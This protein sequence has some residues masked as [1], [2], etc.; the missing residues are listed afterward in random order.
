M[1]V[2]IIAG[3]PTP[4]EEEAVRIAFAQLAAEDKASAANSRSAEGRWA[5]SGRVFAMSAWETASSRS[6]RI[7]R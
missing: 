3:S 2:K 7:G 5:A 4:A 1:E 6:P